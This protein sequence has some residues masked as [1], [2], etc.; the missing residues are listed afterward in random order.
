MDA[1]EHI[2]S[3]IFQ[4]QGYWTIVSYK[5]DLSKEDK[6]NLDNHSMPRPE[7]DIVAYR[8]SEN[9]LLMIECKSYLDSQGVG[10]RGL[11]EEGHRYNKRYKMFT[12]KALRE[13]VEERLVQQMSREGLIAAPLPSPKLC[14]VAGKI[15]ADHETSIQE[16]FDS[17]GWRLFTP[18]WIADRIREVAEKGYENEVMTVV[19]KILERS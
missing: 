11:A 12:N 1:F 10:Y 6:R 15:Y 2:V 17:N 4:D 8:P 13:L 5:V 7:I 9:E 19:T 16:H 14:L 3:K 18:S